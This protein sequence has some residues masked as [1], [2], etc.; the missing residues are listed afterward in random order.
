MTTAAVPTVHASSKAAAY[1]VT[2]VDDGQH[3]WQADEPAEVGGGDTAPSPE[4]LLLSSLG[5]CTAITVRM[6]AERKQ[7]PLAQVEVMLR[8]NPDGKPAAGTDIE[9][10]IVLRGEL[11]DEQRERLLQIANACPIHKVLTGEVRIATALDATAQ[12]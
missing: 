7:W 12:G 6:Y 1:V 3:R 9:R 4:R 8:F 11:S 2:F 10:R 5:A